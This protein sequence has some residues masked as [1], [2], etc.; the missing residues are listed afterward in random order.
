MLHGPTEFGGLAV[1]TLYGE[2]LVA[3]TVF[4][5]H[6][7]RVQDTRTAIGLSMQSEDCKQSATCTMG[8]VGYSRNPRDPYLRTLVRFP[9]PK[10]IPS[11]T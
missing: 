5:L 6:H 4:F 7:M 1:P 9:S 2:D 10:N 8:K 3:K 11:G